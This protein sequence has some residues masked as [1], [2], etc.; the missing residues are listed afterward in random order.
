MNQKLNSVKVMFADAKYNYETNVSATSTK[1]SVNEYFVGKSFDMGIYP[2]ENMQQCIGIEFTD[3]NIIK[4]HSGMIYNPNKTYYVCGARNAW[5]TV[6]IGLFDN[7]AEAKGSFPEHPK[8]VRQAT[9]KEV[10]EFFN[11]PF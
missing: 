7:E 10:N 4:H 3:N 11:I 8:C 9:N 1:E 6:K 2:A 5:D